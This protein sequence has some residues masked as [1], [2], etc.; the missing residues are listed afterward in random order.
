MRRTAAALLAFVCQLAAAHP[1]AAFCRLTT[2]SPSGGDGCA[3]TGIPLEWRRQCIEY[4]LTDTLV[5]NGPALAEARAV[6]DLAFEAWTEIECSSGR[7]PFSL[8][9][10][11]ELGACSEP[12]YNINGKNANT[13]IF[14]DDWAQRELPP[15]ALGLTELWHEPNTGEIF[16]ADMRINQSRGVPALCDQTCPP[17]AFDLLNVMTHEAGHFFG[18][19]HSD[20]PGAT[21]LARASN[22]ETE[23]RSLE[24][25]DRA[26]ACSI[27][28][29]L[30]PPACVGSDFTP[31]NGF[32]AACGVPASARTASG[33]HCAASLHPPQQRGTL[34]TAGCLLGL[35]LLGVRRRSRR[36][37]GQ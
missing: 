4:S 9:Q 34:L 23:K 10:S 11:A 15:A 33:W 32:A 1:A 29:S 13:I 6:T 24:D 28:D 27:Y 22:G 19:G 25:D 14:V 8:R 2:D 7:L 30:A 18:L 37:V 5:A 36:S 21:M 16:D 31:D 35:A 17:G 3:T 26:G 20:V 12:E